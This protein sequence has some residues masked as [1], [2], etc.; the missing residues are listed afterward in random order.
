MEVTARNKSNKELGGNKN[1]TRKKKVMIRWQGD[2][3]LS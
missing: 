3:N 1:M 2:K